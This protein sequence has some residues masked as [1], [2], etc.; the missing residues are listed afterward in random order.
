MP[1]PIENSHRLLPLSANSGDGGAASEDEKVIAR[2][3]DAFY[4]A[5]RDDDLI[6]PIFMGRVTDWDK[7]LRKMCDFWSTIVLQSGRYNG[8]PIQVH[9]NI[10]Q[11]RQDHFDRWLELWRATVEREV[12]HS[13][14]AAFLNPAT[15]MARAMGEQLIDDD[16]EE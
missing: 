8:R 12:P 1:D 16:T 13:A 4:L 5:V 14:R 6:G 15:R 10:P 7:H 2:L 3:V 9:Q 11:L